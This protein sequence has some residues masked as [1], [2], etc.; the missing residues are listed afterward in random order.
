MIPSFPRISKGVRVALNECRTGHRPSQTGVQVTFPLPTHTE[1]QPRINIIL[2]LK[3]TFFTCSR[4]QNISELCFI[5]RILLCCFYK[6][7]IQIHFLFGML[8]SFPFHFC[9]YLFFPN[10]ELVTLV[11]R[12]KGIILKVFKHYE[13]NVISV[14]SGLHLELIYH[15]SK[16]LRDT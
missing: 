16:G 9:I 4:Y 8:K 12:S 1:P 10:R 15:S 7:Q 11:I 13:V 5:W 2:K 3:I 6:E 14:I